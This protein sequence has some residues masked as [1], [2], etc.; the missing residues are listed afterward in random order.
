MR[1]SVAYYA[2]HKH[3]HT[4]RSSSPVTSEV[5]SFISISAPSSQKAIHFLSRPDLKTTF[6]FFVHPV[7]LLFKHLGAGE[8]TGVWSVWVILPDPSSHCDISGKA[9]G[10]FL[11]FR[12]RRP[13]GLVGELIRIWL[14][15]V[16]AEAE[17]LKGAAFPMGLSD[18]VAPKLRFMKSMISAVQLVRK[19][20][21]KKLFS[22][23][24]A[25]CQVVPS[26]MRFKS[27]TLRI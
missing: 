17:A 4:D 19:K 12:S 15:K 26:Q 27:W 8:R 9:W 21:K 1:V 14:W 25:E 10:E 23:E 11:Q 24:A 18:K 13:L 3:L 22:E 2:E 16:R 20:K 7:L 5:P 6:S